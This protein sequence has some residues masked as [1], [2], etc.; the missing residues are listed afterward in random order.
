MA[1]SRRSTKFFTPSA[2]IRIPANRPDRI[3]RPRELGARYRIDDSAL[4][5]R[6]LAGHDQAGAD[7]GPPAYTRGNNAV[8][9]AN[10][11]FLPGQ[12][13]QGVLQY[14]DFPYDGVDPTVDPL[15]VR[16]DD[17]L[18]ARLTYGIGVDTLFQTAGPGDCF[19]G[20]TLSVGV[21]DIWHDSSTIST[22]RSNDVRVL[23]LLAKRFDF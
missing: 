4:H 15:H 11:V 3:I 7:G 22:Y 8:L 14:G 13:L 12:F 21:E 10:W 2:S 6:G 9:S 18:D 19:R 20:L 17:I 1:I 5:R 23:T 16:H